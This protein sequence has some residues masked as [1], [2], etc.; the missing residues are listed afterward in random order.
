MCAA[1]AHGGPDD[2]GFLRD[3]AVC[4]GHKRLSIIDLSSAAHQPMRAAGRNV[5]V[6]YNGE[7]YNFPELR[8]E[9]SLLG[10]KFSSA[11][12]TEVIISAYLQWGEEAFA[13]FSGMF[14]FCLY[15]KENALVYLVRDAVGIKPLYYS[16]AGEQL[17]FASEVRAFKSVNPAWPEDPDWRPLFLAFGHL[18]APV[19][20][21][22]GVGSFPKGS[23][24]RLNLASGASELK[25]FFSFEFSETINDPAS[26]V[27][28]SRRLI[29]AAVKRHLISDAP[30]GVFL[31]GGLDSSIISALAYKYHGENLRTLSITFEESD[32]SE[33]AFQTSIVN[34]IKCRHSSFRVTRRDFAESVPD[35][36]AAMDQPT[37]DG[38]NTYFITKYAKKEGFKAVLSG[39]GADELYGGYGS[40]NRVGKIAWVN[41]LPDFVRKPAVMADFARAGKYRRTSYL[42]RPNELSAYLFLR[43]I[44]SPKEIAGTLGGTEGGVLR[45]LERVAFS[46]RKKLDKNYA[47]HMETELYLQNQILKDTDS[48]GMWNSVEVRVP[49]LDRDSM[50]YA[51]SVAQKIKFPNGDGKSLLRKAF[52]DIIPAEILQRKKM[53]FSFPFNEWLS[54]KEVLSACSSGRLSKASVGGHWSRAWGLVVME[55]FGRAAAG[56]AVN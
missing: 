37:T 16:L 34:R 45:A 18:P 11:S 4:L 50:S 31:S 47:S 56:R 28:S 22:K 39:I 52:R 1:M 24:L 35:I 8:K 25:K 36:F 10:H 53:G 12:D 5:W 13:K 40:F 27:A 3:G 54:D 46:G 48:M 30:I 29:D 33:E 7:I 43:G 49:F 9:L 32:Y 44:F 19:T 55:R 23:F 2:T 20:T 6:T 26:A 21:L 15:D 38:V 42:G 17:I 41:A 14:A 51:L